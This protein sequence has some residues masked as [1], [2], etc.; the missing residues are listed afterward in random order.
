MC[1]VSLVDLT[2][3]TTNT[4]VAETTPTPA[5]AILEFNATTKTSRK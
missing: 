4:A 2:T 3:T 5:E 1:K